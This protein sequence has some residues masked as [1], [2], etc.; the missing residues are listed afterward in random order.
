M[1]RVLIVKQ[2]SFKISQI[3][4]VK[5]EDDDDGDDEEERLEDSKVFKSEAS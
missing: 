1:Q 4:V 3:V 2:I 5:E